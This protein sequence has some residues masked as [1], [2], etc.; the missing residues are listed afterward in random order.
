MARHWRALRLH[1]YT[2][3]FIY[4][5]CDLNQGVTGL[6]S[7]GIFLVYDS[8]KIMLGLPTTSGISKDKPRV[9]NPEGDAEVL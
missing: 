3:L 9:A 7:A 5:F 6:L 4:F 8:T 1:W 2:R